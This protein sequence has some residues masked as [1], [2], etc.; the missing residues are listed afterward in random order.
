[1]GRSQR[2]MV[3]NYHT[4]IIGHVYDERHL[5]PM[6]RAQGAGPYTVKTGPSG[7]PLKGSSL[8]GAVPVGYVAPTPHAA[9]VAALPAAGEVRKASE[10]R[11]ASEEA[12][13]VRNLGPFSLL[14]VEVVDEDTVR[15]V[16]ANDG[17]ELR[18]G[19]TVRVEATGNTEANGD[20]EL[21]AIN[22]TDDEISF[23]C[24]GITLTSV[25][26]GKGRL[27]IIEN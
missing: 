20:I 16:I 11:E 4:D 18:K 26:T 1:M 19:E 12:S 8:M 27:T 10:V 25:I 2:H 14:R 23:E 15:Y 21:G 5:A 13:K 22:V 3:E 7:G 24:T 6:M 9:L 17:V